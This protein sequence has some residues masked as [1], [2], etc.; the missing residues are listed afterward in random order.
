MFEKMT[1][2]LFDPWVTVVVHAPSGTI[3]GSAIS[4]ANDPG[5]VEIDALTD[6]LGKNQD[7]N[8]TN[9]YD[10][11]KL[12]ID[13]HIISA[14]FR[15]IISG[16]GIQITH[17]SNRRNFKMGMRVEVIFQKLCKLMA[18]KQPNPLELEPISNLNIMT[19]TEFKQ[20]LKKY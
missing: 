19:E 16:A 12:D 3:L 9:M 13:S 10:V 1:D 17:H 20:R 2:Q 11:I 14:R 15:Q 5:Q 7:E 6:A 4:L 8:G 18:A